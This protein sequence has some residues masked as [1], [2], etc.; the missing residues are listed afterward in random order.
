MDMCKD[1]LVLRCS[2]CQFSGRWRGWESHVHVSICVSVSVLSFKGLVSG[3]TFMPVNLC[4]RQ[5]RAV[6]RGLHSIP[7]TNLLS[8]RF[9]F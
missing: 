8:L 4:Q 9:S 3:A 1:G 7:L 5:V 2:E 6:N